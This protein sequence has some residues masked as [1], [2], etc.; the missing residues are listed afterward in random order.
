MCVLVNSFKILN[1]FEFKKKLKN[2]YT[3]LSIGKQ[4]YENNL[5]VSYRTCDNEEYI[6]NWTKSEAFTEPL[7][8]S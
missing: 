6:C 4:L 1:G 5:Q 3:D 8:R 7:N 2:A